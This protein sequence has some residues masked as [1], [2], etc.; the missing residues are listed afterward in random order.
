MEI[1]W[2]NVENTSSGSFEVNSIGEG[3]VWRCVDP[4]YEDSGHW[5]KVK[6]ERHSKSKVKVLATVD[7]ERIND[8]KQLAERLAHNGRL[9]QI[10]QTTFNLLNGGE[11]DIKRIGDL[12]K[13]VMSDI[14]KED[15]LLI[16]ENGFTFKDISGPVAKIVRD[17][18][19]SELQF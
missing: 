7:V 5:F 19:L 14:A 13:A 11:V 16:A 4:G 8:I 6:D 15:T 3:I 12:I 2:K 1:K 9:E 17:Y 10:A 18:V